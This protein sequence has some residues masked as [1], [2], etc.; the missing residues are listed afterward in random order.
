MSQSALTLITETF[1][2]GEPM[3]ATDRHRLEDGR[4]TEWEIHTYPLA[5]SAARVQQTGGVDWAEGQTLDRPSGKG[6]DLSA[7]SVPADGAQRV[8]Q[9]MA[10]VVDAIDGS[11]VE[12]V[13][14]V[15][16]DVTEER[17][18]EAS[19]IQSEKLAAV[20]RLA[21]GVAHEINNPLTVIL[22][23]TQ[24]LREEI[25]TTHP[26]YGSIELISRASER[27]SRVVRNLLDFSRAEQFEF[28]PTD[29]NRSLED[30]VSLVGSQVRKANIEIVTDLAPGLPPIW[31][32]PD[33]LHVVWLNLLL[34]ARDA[35]V[36]ADREGAIRVSSRRD[37]ERVVV[38]VR[39]NGVGMPLHMLG[40]IFDPFFTTKPP[41]Q[42]TGLGLFT[43]YRTVQRHGGEINVDS[44]AG[45]GTSFEIWLPIRQEAL[46]A[47]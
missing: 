35:I 38:H 17:W 22:A 13:I 31:A 7:L 46:P 33:H 40:R 19:L 37:G 21:A 30:A 6:E 5:N 47:D 3:S 29:L 41:G 45:E 28:V 10:P 39:D 36:E 24:I 42:G 4:W 23:N 14:V 25:A 20:G 27:T 32:S 1:A 44:Q 18:L 12:R 2:S 9:Q 8:R 26:Y 34:N 11:Q 15:V 16:R 43:C